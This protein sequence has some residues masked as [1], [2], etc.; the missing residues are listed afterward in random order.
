MHYFKHYY[1]MDSYVMSCYANLELGFVVELLGVED[2]AVHVED[3]VRHGVG[4]LMVMAV[5]FHCRGL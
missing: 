3:D 1:V 5:I 4:G 2:C